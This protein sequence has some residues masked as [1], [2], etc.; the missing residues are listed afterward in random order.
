[1]MVI[2]SRPRQTETD[3]DR[4]RRLH[5]T[6]EAA[7]AA[8]VAV[9]GPN[10]TRDRRR[11]RWWMAVG[12]GPRQTAT[13]RQLQQ[14]SE[15]GDSCTTRGSGGCQL[16]QIRLETDGGSLGDGSRRRT[17]TDRDRRRQTETAAADLRGSDS[18]TRQQR[19]AGAVGG[20]DQTRDR[21]R[22]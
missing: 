17:E 10:Q 15:V 12:G 9:G 18:C 11:Q 21:R 22:Q 6:R 3:G 19:Q 13:D 4:Q 16:T 14:T 7:T 8:A 20:S 1:M 5:Q 2:D